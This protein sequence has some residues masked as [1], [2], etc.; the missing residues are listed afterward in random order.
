MW[1]YRRV[2]PSSHTPH[3]GALIPPK[4]YHWL[5]KQVS[6]H[7][8][9]LLQLWSLLSCNQHLFVVPA[10]ATGAWQSFELVRKLTGFP[11]QLHGYAFPHQVDDMRKREVVSNKHTLFAS[12]LDALTNNLRSTTILGTVG[13][14]GS[15]LPSLQHLEYHSHE[16]TRENIWSFASTTTTTT[17]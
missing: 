15:T 14:I 3:A 7:F 9:S 16:I 6:S 10:I 8:L 12:A 5:W 17:K 4:Y 13:I 11:S 2:E 1:S